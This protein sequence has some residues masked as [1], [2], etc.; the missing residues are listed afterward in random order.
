MRTH[1]IHVGILQ[2]PSQALAK[3][4][5]MPSGLCVFLV[6]RTEQDK[7]G[8]RISKFLSERT[9][10]VKLG[11]SQ[12]V[13]PGEWTPSSDALGFRAQLAFIDAYFDDLYTN[14]PG[15]S[16]VG[17]RSNQQQ[18]QQE[19]GNTDDISR[20]FVSLA[21]MVLSEIV[22]G[23]D[24]PSIDAVLVNMINSALDPS[25]PYYDGSEDRIIY[26]LFNYNPSTG[27]ADG[28]GFIHLF[29]RLQIR[30]E[31]GKHNAT[32]TINARSAVYSETDTLDAQYQWAKN[33]HPS[34]FRLEGIPPRSEFK[35]F[36]SLPTLNSDT[37][38]SALIL[39]STGQK[40]TALVFYAANL[41]SI[42]NLDNK[43]SKASS[44]YSIATTSG[45]FPISIPLSLSRMVHMLSLSQV[46]PSP[47]L[48]R[49][50]FQRRQKLEL[51]L[52]RRQ[53][54][55]ASISP[56]LSSGT[57]LPLRPSNSRYSFF[58]IFL[59]SSPFRY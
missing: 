17:R 50:V 36:D 45:M 10:G 34:R 55:S 48:R 42:G 52:R 18:R 3:S 15:F 19:V 24:Q 31:G 37:W 21:E 35:V 22:S 1:G 57:L 58:L 5:D 41:S 14:Y 13:A 33:R 43:A 26:I 49:L 11:D 46:S 54:Q 2:A 40:L 6:D 56:S 8:L 23:I 51:S 9:R 39:E 38:N 47:F 28:I 7:R 20:L 53:L 32:I 27:S 25:L 16:N 30:K 44:T 29:W 59:F 12:P 4:N